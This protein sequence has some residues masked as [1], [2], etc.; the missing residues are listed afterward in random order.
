M[1]SKTETLFK[2]LFMTKKS[3]SSE[4]ILLGVP[5]MLDVILL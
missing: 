2:N 4:I 3:L 5:V 1:V